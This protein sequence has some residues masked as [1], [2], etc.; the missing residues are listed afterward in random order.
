MTEMRRFGLADALLLLVV[1]LVAA[2]S[3]ASYLWFCA[4]Q[5]RQSGPL[6]VQGSVAEE[7]DTLVANLKDHSWFGCLAPLARVEERTAHVAP[8]YPWLLG[9]AARLPIALEPTVRWTQCGLGALTTGLYFLFARRAFRNLFVASLTGLACAL[10]PFWIINTAELA[11]GVL[12]TFLLAA[13]LYLGSRASQSGGSFTSLLYGLALAGTA[14]VRATLLPFAFVGLLWFLLRSRSLPRGWLLALLAF[15]GFA[16]GL[17]PWTLRNVQTFHDVTLV[18]SAYLHLYMGN[19]P[20]AT[21]GP[22][23]E[24]ELIRALAEQHDESAEDTARRL[25]DL[26]QGQR[27]SSLA[28]AVIDEVGRNPLGAVQRRLSAGLYFFFGEEWFREQT[29]WQT[30]AGGEETAV[31]AWLGS[32]YPVGL[33]GTLLGMLLLGVLGWRWT[34]GWR[35]TAMPAA[36]AAIWVPL[37]YLLSHA[38]SLQGPRLP[39]DGVLLCC[40]A[41]AVAYLIPFTQLRVRD[42]NANP[43]APAER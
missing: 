39:L 33:T 11:D 19:N 20:H 36:L 17:T 38:E 28:G 24:R 26:P 6:E 41:F 30:T 40:A 42:A 4:D 13:C 22:L 5:A 2:G 31:P 15:L 27:Y 29:L 14:L 37:P 10:Y 3:R 21:G 16:N 1:L 9:Q 34:Y 35:R 12:T 8:G 43:Q 32:A 25:A 23:P 7:R 18:N